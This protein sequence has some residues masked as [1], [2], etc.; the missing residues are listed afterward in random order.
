MEDLRV[1]HVGDLGNI[2]ANGSG[3]AYGTFWTRGVTLFGRNSVLGRS[4]VVHAL[5]DDLGKG[6]GDQ[7]PES[8]RTGNAGARL[9]CGV[10]GLAPRS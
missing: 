7:R 10:I 8:L 5:P 1:R 3:V 6:Q 4:F 9:A 2:V